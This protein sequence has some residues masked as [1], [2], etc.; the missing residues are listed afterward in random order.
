MIRALATASAVLLAT[1]LAT[2][3]QAAAGTFDIFGG[4]PRDI[5]MGGG[6]T[7]AVL[8]P[9]ALYYNPAAL[10]RQKVHTLGA[11]FHLSVPLLY[12][13]RGDP[14]AE[15][16]TV[17]PETHTG[18][19]LGWVKPLG[20]IFDDRLALGVSISLPTER[21]ARVQGVDPAAP[22]FYLYQNLQD[23]LLI[24]L[25]VAAEPFDWLSVG[26]SL[27]ILAD[28]AGTAL[29][30]M[31]LLGGVFEHR[32]I[33][34]TLEPTMA[35]FFGVHL[36]PPLGQGG[37]QLQIGAAY[38]GSSSMEFK[39]PVLVSAGEGLALAI[40]MH[41]V[42]LWVPDEL[43]FGLSY[44]LD[45]PALT[46][47]ADVTYAMWSDAPDPS[48]RLSVDVGGRLVEALGLSE[49]LDLSTRT[50][51]IDLGFI[52]TITIRAGAE[53]VASSWLTLRG[54]YTFRP[55]PAPRQTGAT[56]YLDNDAHIIA[57]GAGFSFVNPLQKRKSIVDIDVSAQATIL[58]RRT[59][60]R[61]DPLNPGGDL[62]HGGALLHF[63]VGVMH[64][65]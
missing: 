12:V 60:Y 52:D 13:D 27:Q 46:F 57:L 19:S 31:N 43:A 18:V 42:V 61:T 16:Q 49:A 65:F 3:P 51:P 33:D 59:A 4:S 23:K 53:W 26:C 20:G 21:L 58:P 54:G 48:P 9:T 24:H 40:D 29:L 22:Q 62:S 17:L 38:R 63:A 7:A 5:G 10:T 36:R 34:V 44:T 11:S 55:T 47:A 2:A 39:L 6:M 30:D 45:E 32:S 37:G 28:L 56:A 64:Y 8:G 25:G 50:S 14:D 35:P 1:A 15:P 41:Q